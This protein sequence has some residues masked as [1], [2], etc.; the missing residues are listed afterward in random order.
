MNR[1]VRSLLALAV[2]VS[3]RSAGAQGALDSAKVVASARPDIEAANADWVPGL[4]TRDA[5][6]IVSAY[7]DTGVFVTADGQSIRGRGAI[8]A[9]YRARFPR[10]AP[11][12]SGQVTPLRIW[13]MS[14]D[15]VV[16]V[17]HAWLE[18]DSG[19]PGAKPVRGGGAYVTVWQRQADGR[20]RIARNAAL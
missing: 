16:E 7:A 19:E 1:T 3:A 15:L 6:R 14:S 8:A 20:W 18:Q 10:L 17:G 11:R 2:A 12:L 4:Q 13:A 5:D 9:M